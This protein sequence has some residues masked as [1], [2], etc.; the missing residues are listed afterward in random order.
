MIIS[1]VREFQ[2]NQ[3]RFYQKG[4]KYVRFCKVCRGIRPGRCLLCG[5]T[6]TVYK[7][8]FPE[9]VEHSQDIWETWMKLRKFNMKTSGCDNVDKECFRMFG[10]WL[11]R[12]EMKPI[13]PRM[14]KKKKKLLR[15]GL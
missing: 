14:K 5:Q 3:L 10:N 1:E 4:K 2:E 13:P 7:A 6:Q 11:P 12:P 8:T 9:L 15:G